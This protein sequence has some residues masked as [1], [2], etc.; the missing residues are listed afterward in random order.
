VIETTLTLAV[1]GQGSNRTLISRL[2]VADDP[3]SG[4]AGHTVTFYAD[5]TS[6]GSATTDEDGVA[7]LAVPRRLRGGKHI[8]EARFEGDNEYGASSAQTSG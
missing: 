1:E 2:S 4:I 8:F 6:I 5:G 7:T 3:A